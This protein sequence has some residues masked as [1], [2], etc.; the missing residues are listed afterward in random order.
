MS[1]ASTTDIIN[2]QIEALTAEH[3]HAA[4]CDE[5]L[6]AQARAE[7]AGVT[8]WIGGKSITRTVPI[9]QFG[10]LY[11][12]PLTAQFADANAELRAA[13]WAEGAPVR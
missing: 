1:T 8:V 4:G 11:S 3:L 13:R 10:H 12:D 7:Y 6:D 2:D 5:H 9:E